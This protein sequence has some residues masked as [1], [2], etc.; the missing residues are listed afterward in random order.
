MHKRFMMHVIIFVATLWLAAPSMPQSH[1]NELSPQLYQQ[2]RD[3]L[4]KTIGDNSALILFSALPKMREWDT[5]YEYVQDSNF[6]DFTGIDK[7]NGALLLVPQGVEEVSFPT[8]VGSGPNSTKPHYWE[9]RWRMEDGAVVVLNLGADLHNY[10]ADITRTIP[11]NGKF[12][13][14]Q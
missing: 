10:A 5:P 11:I 4:M 13:P 1:S 14:P 2:R 7:E 8:I 9:N 12:S 3:V 6:F